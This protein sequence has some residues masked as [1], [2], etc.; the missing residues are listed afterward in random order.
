MKSVPIEESELWD[1]F[2]YG[3]MSLSDED[4]AEWLYNKLT[5]D[6][7]HDVDRLF[8]NSPNPFMT[9]ILLISG[10]YDRLS[11]HNKTLMRILFPEL[12]DQYEKY[13]QEDY[14]TEYNNRAR[15]RR[16]Y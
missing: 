11:E 12:F 15:N 1:N 8:P 3:V 16:R 7:A 10:I 13:W 5:V 9:K 6:G 2:Y 14:L 4:A